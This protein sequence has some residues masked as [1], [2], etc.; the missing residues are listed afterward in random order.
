VWIRQGDP[1]RAREPLYSSVTICQQLHD[2]LGVALLLRTIGEMHLATGD[3]ASALTELQA[4]YAGWQQLDHDLGKA[5]TLRD[6]GAAHAHNGDCASAH[7]AWRS[8][9]G[10]FTTLGTREEGELIEWRRRWGCNCG[11]STTGG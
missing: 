1:E 5:R 4:A 6:I 3:T 8:A 9:W 2:R 7:D 11:D 10:T